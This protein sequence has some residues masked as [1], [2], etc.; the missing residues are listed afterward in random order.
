VADDPIDHGI[1]G[2][3]GNDAHLALAFG[4]SK[5]VYF[6]NFA[7]HLGPAAAGNPWVFLLDDD[8]LV[9]HFIG[10]AHFAPMGIGIEAELC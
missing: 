2:E 5:R 1:V 9:S 8:Q 4:A 6:I 3:E 7:D 10:L